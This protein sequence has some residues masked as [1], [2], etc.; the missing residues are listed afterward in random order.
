MHR[1]VGIAGPAEA[2]EAWEIIN[3]MR[4]VIAHGT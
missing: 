1:G 4:V 2:V 3:G